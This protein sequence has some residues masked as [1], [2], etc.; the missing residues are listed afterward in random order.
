MQSLG[1]R[2]TLLGTPSLTHF[3]GTPVEGMGLGKPLGILAYL[4]VHGPA[5]RDELIGL[6]WGN[7][8]EQKARNAF[9]QTLHRLRKAI[10][11]S[12]VST[13][14]GPLM[15]GSD[16]P[17]ESDVSRFSSAVERGAFLDAVSIYRGPFLEGFELGE[18]EFDQWA[19]GERARLE[20]KYHWALEQAI[21][22][23]SMAGEI[24]AALGLAS[25][26]AKSAPFAAAA[27][28]TEARLLVGAGRALEARSN[29]EQFIKRYRTEFEEEPPI[30]IRE[31]LARLRKDAGPRV[32][33]SGE[34]ESRVLIGREAELGKLLA[35]WDKACAGKG[36]L[37]LIQ[38]ADGIGKSALM[39]E[40]LT[41]ASRIG[42]I[43]QLQGRERSSDAL[44]PYASIA[45]ALRGALNAPGLAGASQHLLAEAARLLPELRDQFDLPVLQNI[46]DAASE[47]RFYEGIAALLDAVAYEEPVCLVLEDFHSATRASSQLLEYLCGRLG[48]VAIAIVVVFRSAH[49]SAR[50]PGFP[51]SLRSGSDSAITGISMP[52]MHLRVEPLGETDATALARTIA[53]AE[54]LPQD[55]CERIA[56]IS[57]GVPYRIL[58]MSRQA[59]GGLRIAALPAT[60]QDTLWARLQACAPSQQRLFVAAALIERPA[61][62]RLLAAA[63]H[64]SESAALDAV[65]A[66]EGRGLLRQTPQGV[67][68]EHHE[69]ALLALKGTGPAGRA[70]LAGWAAEAMAN[71]PNARPSELAHLFDL[72]GNNKEC[73]RSSVAAA[74]E[75]GALRDAAAVLHFIRMAEQVAGSSDERQTIE[76][77]RRSFEPD[78]QRFLPNT[79]AYPQPAQ[80]IAIEGKLDAPEVQTYSVPDRTGPVQRVLWTIVKSTPV[81]IA[82]A[83]SLIVGITSATLGEIQSRRVRVLVLSDTLFLVNRSAP[84][85]SLYYVT[86]ELVA[87]TAPQ[88]YPRRSSPS[89]VD[90]VALPLMNPAVSPTG[91][92]VA[93]ERMRE[94]GPDILLFSADGKSFKEIA[95]EAGDDIIA[96]W[97]PDGN[98]LLAT[99]AR[100]LPTGDYDA[101]LFAINSDG[102]RINLDVSPTR[103][104]VEAVWSPDGTHIA[105]TARVGDTHQQEVYVSNAAG[106]GLVNISNS[107]GE[108]F[109]IAWSRDGGRVAFTSDRFGSADIFSYELGTRKLWRLTT[110]PAQDDYAIFSPDGSFVA[111]ESTAEGIASVYIVRSFGGNP[112]RIAGGDQNF[113]I[114]KWSES[115]V[116]SSYI[117][118]VRIVAPS[119]VPMSGTVTARV[120]AVSPNNT[121]LLP[122][123]VTWTNLDPEFLRLREDTSSAEEYKN[124]NATLTGLKPGLARVAISAG[125][126]R[127][128]TTLLRV[129]NERI[130]LITDD[131]SRG[132]KAEQWL[133][134]GDSAPRLIAVAGERQLSLRSGRQMEN[135]IISRALLPMHNGFFASVS[136]RAPLAAPTAQRSFRIS[137]VLPDSNATMSQGRRQTRLATVEWIGQAARISYSVD[138]ETWTEPVDVLG[139]SETHNFALFVDDQGKVAFH[140]DGKLRWK[141]RLR[142]RSGS[143]PSRLWLGSQGAADLVS[144]G[145]VQAGL[146]SVTQ[147]P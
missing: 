56:A 141:S 38:G 108:D 7:M 79:P 26:F 127:A 31:S 30:G 111:F 71:E 118:N 103:S 147:S 45:Q 114:S 126:W 11:E 72:A 134:V 70:L 33:A 77:I 115:T 24:D 93:V 76:A 27:V 122:P 129:G 132:L 12:L 41:R 2:V 63:S 21:A 46:E 35:A 88:L 119:Q 51:F 29:L 16:H 110:D 137:L 67:T 89:W 39:E 10:G 109:H 68:P 83:I 60:L 78:R 32:S 104:V 14:A 17:I 82:A 138:R 53:E 123:V 101:D 3:D 44:L 25:R 36:N 92:D 143:L 37:I 139:K 43:L 48:S 94:A 5:R 49:S 55:E 28:E 96:G 98:W 64:L 13:T 120:D 15:L 75:A 74:Y 125:G 80:E 113:A 69:A 59:A 40:F 23:S 42:P 142:I 91:R 107:S 73:F 140:V 99:H 34:S 128:D 112:I 135:G 87:G 20:G 131:F 85:R 102:Q 117:A 58:D 57:G 136:V 105:W 52:V 47:L 8:A 19:L 97:A 106:D 121:R 9:R 144:F 116:A 95:A 4:I 61:S 145:K 18:S 65:F 133:T 84:T 22:A 66:L 6:F 130:D 124:L 100:S 90:S 146:T 62:I 50:A 81:Q 54:V 1:L 86:G